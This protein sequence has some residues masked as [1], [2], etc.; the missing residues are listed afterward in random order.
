MSYSVEHRSW[1]ELISRGVNALI[2][3]LCVLLVP[4][5]LFVGSLWGAP[6]AGLLVQIFWISVLPLLSMPL[7][8]RK[9]ERLAGEER[10]IT[11]T[12]VRF[13]PVALFLVVGP[14]LAWLTKA[15]G[16]ELVGW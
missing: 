2:A 1:P 12:V 6:F 13:V 8:Y 10:E 14:A 7:S 9:A 5:A 15:I 4:Y 16:M 11:A 3:L